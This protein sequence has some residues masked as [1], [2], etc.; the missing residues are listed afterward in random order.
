MECFVQNFGHLFLILSPI[1]PRIYSS[2][3][4]ILPTGFAAFYSQCFCKKCENHGCYSYYSDFFYEKITNYRYI[5]WFLWKSFFAKKYLLFCTFFWILLFKTSKSCRHVQRYRNKPNSG[6]SSGTIHVSTEG[7]QNVG[8]ESFHCWKN[9]PQRTPS[10][11]SAAIAASF[12]VNGFSTE[13]HRPFHCAFGMSPLFSATRTVSE[14]SDLWAAG[15]IAVSCM[16]IGIHS[17]IHY[18]TP[19]R[20]QHRFRNVLIIGISCILRKFLN[21]WNKFCDSGHKVSVIL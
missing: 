3:G 8:S 21:K 19:F 20:K 16:S 17:G 15:Q 7:G 9:C 11:E 4:A 14:M 12:A 1:C 6:P 10:R 18:G 2:N 5:V 13:R